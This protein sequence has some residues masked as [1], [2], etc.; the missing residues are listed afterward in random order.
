[1]YWDSFSVWY[2]IYGK[3]KKFNFVRQ[4]WSNP[5][6]ILLFLLLCLWEFR[7]FSTYNW[8]TSWNTH[9]SWEYLK[10]KVRALHLVSWRP[11]LSPCAA[12]PAPT[13]ICRNSDWLPQHRG[14]GLYCKLQA[15]GRIRSKVP[16][17]WE[18]MGSSGS[19]SWKTA[20][21]DEL[22]TL[23]VTLCV[24]LDHNGRL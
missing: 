13:V 17:P 15:W 23:C 24:V 22:K 18:S 7:F 16:S 20:G 1:M 9:L 11:R 2:L 6:R 14:R 3:I 21:K 4:I 12:R 8:V 5:E 10:S 19:S